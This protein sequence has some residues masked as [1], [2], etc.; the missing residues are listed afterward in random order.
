MRI[1]LTVAGA[2]AILT[3]VVWFFQGI[4]MLPG[5]FMTGQRQWA[6][7]GAITTALGFGLL[8]AARRR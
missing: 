2:L 4:G 1:V 8:A 5:S 6:I 3:G 7:F